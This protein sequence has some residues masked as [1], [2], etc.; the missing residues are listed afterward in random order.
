MQQATFGLLAGSVADGAS[1]KNVTLGGSLVFGDNCAAL[2]G[3]SDFTVKTVVGNGS[4][5][6]ITAEEI[7]VVKKNADKIGFNL[8]T[9]ADGTVTIVS[10]S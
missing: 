2:V 4:S 7:T 1:F 8:K 5:T 6:G 10:G 3:R 9:E